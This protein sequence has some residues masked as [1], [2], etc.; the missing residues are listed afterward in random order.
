M[1]KQIGNLDK[2]FQ[3][4]RLGD[5][6]CELIR[7]FRPVA[8]RPHLSTGLPLSDGVLFYFDNRIEFG[9]AL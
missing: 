1:P 6:V 7:G 9:I 4:R 2:D 5:L 3:L 8:L